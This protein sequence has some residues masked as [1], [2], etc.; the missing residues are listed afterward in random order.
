MDNK[1]QQE[2]LSVILVANCFVIKLKRKTQI[3]GQI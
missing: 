1:L 2:E 3:G